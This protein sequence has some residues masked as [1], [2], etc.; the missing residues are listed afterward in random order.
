MNIPASG[1]QGRYVRVQLSSANYLSL[2]EVQVFGAIGVAPPTYAI[3]G[4]VTAAGT[5]GGLSGVT[6][7]LTGSATASTT[8]DASGNY[9]FSGLASGGNYSVTPSLSGYSFAPS[10]YPVN[11]LTSN[12]VANFAGTATGGNSSLSTRKSA[13]QSST[14]PGYPASLAVDGNTDGDI[15][16]GS[17][18]VTAGTDTYPWWQVDLGS[19]ATL[20]SI[21]IW[22]RTD[23]CGSRLSDY[24]LFVSDTPFSASDTPASLQ[25]R[26]GTWSNHQTN[27]PAPSVSIP[28]PGAQGRYVRVQLSSANYLSLAE[29]QVFGAIGVAP[30]TYTISGRVTLAGT[31]T[32]ISAVTVSLSGGATASTSTDAS[33]NYSFSGLASGANYSV[34]PSLSGYI[35]APSS[36]LISNL[37]SNQTANFAATV[38]V[39]TSNLAAGKSASQSSTYPGYPA[40]LAVDGNTDGNVSHGSLT[41]TAGTDTYPWWQVDLGSSATLS[42]ISVWNR[43]DCCGS[44]LSDY[45]VFVSD[46]PFSAGDTPA[47]LQGRAG[48]WS[49]HQT[50]APSPSTSITASGAQG[51]YVRLQLSSANYLSLA[52]VQVFGTTSPTYS[53]SGQ[54]TALYAGLS[55]VALSLSGSTTGSTSTNAS[56]NYSFTGVPAGGNYTVTPSLAGY[57][58]QPVNYVMTNLSANQ[59]ANFA[60]TS[61]TSGTNLAQS[62]TATQSSTY[63]GYPASLAVDGNTDGSVPH[64]S[65]TITAGTDAFSW[66]EVDLG[67]SATVDCIVVWN[68]T[69]CCGSRLADY[70]VFV[71]NTPFADSDTPATLQSRAGTWNSH[72]TT[73][74]S[75]SS[76]LS[77]GGVSG[78]YIRVQLSGANYLSLAEVQVIGH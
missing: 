65:V 61:T 18:T 35:F 38:T 57:T 22:N 56:G 42:S 77:A 15:S 19:S 39:G 13:S 25:G 7:S 31:T 47:T 75:P 53:I 28:A 44:R 78:R 12:Q 69:D 76:N 29:V 16:H 51:R 24:W 9:S 52:E 40:S 5:T 43:T 34:I 33:G 55:G 41:V 58:F 3:S 50:S 37:I 6:L 4:Q 74:P 66:W 63:P 70:W 20:S 46:T 64:G 30:P 49:S 48:T 60:A 17:V 59:M 10:T 71:S 67:S 27:T 23:C 73:A 68:R 45:W 8:T 26:A 11:T 1:T 32:G 54:I 2:A 72:Q 14:Y 36:F 62:K 21:S